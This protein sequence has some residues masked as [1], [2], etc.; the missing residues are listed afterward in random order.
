VDY[1]DFRE[2][3]RKAWTWDRIAKGTHEVNCWYQRCC[4]WDL[5]IKDGIVWREE[6]SATY[7]QTRPE[8][9]DFNPRG[10]QKGAC[11]SQRMYG[12]SRLRHPLKRVGA[13]GEGRWKRISWEQALREIADKSLDV[14]ATDGPGS[15][16]W[17]EGSGGSNVGVQRTHIILDTPILDLD[18]EFGDHHPGAAVTCG[19][20][21]F[22]SSADDLHYSD[23]IL[24]W[25]GNPTYTQIPN[26]HFINEARYSG[27]R[28]VTI[29][30]DYNASAIH[31]DQWI[32]IHIASDAALLVRT[33]TGR[34]L[35]ASDLEK[36]GAEDTF[37]VY[38]EASNSIREAPRK[39]LELEGVEP[40]LD[41][42]FQVKTIDRDVP[43]VPV[44]S[45]L[46]RHLSRYSPESV[47]ETTGVS[48]KLVRDLAREIAGAGAATVLTQ[49]NF[50]DGASAVP[51]ARTRGA[52]R[53]EGKRH[54]RLPESLALGPRRPDRRLGLPSAAFR[55]RG[56]GPQRS[57]RNAEDEVEGPYP[58]N[59]D[60]RADA[61]QPRW[62]RAAI[63]HSLSLLPRRPR[64]TLRAVQGVGPEPSP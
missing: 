16:V 25:G 39:S 44:F 24:I 23:L 7:P 63:Q 58:G 32:P 15:I 8:V 19:K 38:D 51:R 60:V 45:L 4:S 48:P 12:P 61:G 36:R 6:Q 20:I 3:Y 42:E 22:A 37:F 56:Q 26:A 35:R 64:R 21:S 27:A 5:F 62:R 28:V 31:G 9:P 41:G 34:F 49:A 10:C 2:F 30:P 50:G 1:Q 47:E 40:A 55:P 33:D 13:R 46:R 54:Q 53:E 52:V 11:F 18:S 59:D 17:D 43:V 57:A 14:L 29:S